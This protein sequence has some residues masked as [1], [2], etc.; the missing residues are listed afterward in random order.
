VFS[1]Q[2][3]LV[4]HDD[5]VVAATSEKNDRS[6]YPKDSGVECFPF[7]FAEVTTPFLN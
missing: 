3:V 6:Y 7:C 5:V 2:K 1:S 4:V